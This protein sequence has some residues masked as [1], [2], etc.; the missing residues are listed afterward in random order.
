VDE[1][2]EVPLGARQAG[3]N[4][5]QF[6]EKFRFVVE[7]PVGQL[8]FCMRPDGFDRVQLWRVCR[9]RLEMKPRK[10]AAHFSD[11]LI[12]VNPGV[13]PDHENV[14]TQ[15]SQQMTQEI[16]D[17]AGMDIGFLKA[18]VQTERFPFRAD[19]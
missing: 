2:A 9:Q 19:R 15:V 1:S 3:E 18:K 5:V 8:L 16:G 7:R 11:R 10:L 14:S 6:V 17:I 12:M 4:P 13:V